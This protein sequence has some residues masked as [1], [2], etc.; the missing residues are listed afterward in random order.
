M[1][2]RKKE[3]PRNLHYDREVLENGKVRYIESPPGESLRVQD[4]ENFFKYTIN[5]HLVETK[6]EKASAAMMKEKGGVPKELIF[7]IAI[8]M[9]CAGIAYS[10]INNQTAYADMSN[11]YTACAISL[12][13]YQEPV[14]T[15]E[16]NQ[17]LANSISNPSVVP[18]TLR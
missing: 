10:M 4:V 7:G 8:V 6:I 15:A 1:I 16:T 11:K 5:P 12:G 14:V 3:E 13:R 2:G 17:K 18:T 9:V